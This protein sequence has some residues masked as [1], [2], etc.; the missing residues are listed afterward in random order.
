M[1][2]KRVFL[3]KPCQSRWPTNGDE[4]LMH[5]FHFKK[6]NIHHSTFTYDTATQELA[7]SR[8]TPAKRSSGAEGRTR[9]EGE[10]EETTSRSRRRRRR[11]RRKETTSSRRRRRRRVWMD[12][13]IN[14]LHPIY[15][16]LQNSI[17]IHAS[18]L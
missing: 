4:N 17:F 8:Q 7:H 16:S 1:R 5:A 15:I 18:H 2:K 13:S 14:Y 6:N 10:E 12:T 11:R 3:S 9:R